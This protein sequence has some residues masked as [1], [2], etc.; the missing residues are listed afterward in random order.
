M[1]QFHL[2]VVLESLGLPVRAGLMAAAKLGVQ[3]VQ[4]DAVGDLAHDRLGATGRREFRTLLRSFNQELAAVNVPLRHGLD[5]F[6]HQ[7][8]RLDHVKQVMQLAYELG[9]KKVVVPLPRLPKAEDKPAAEPTPFLF[10][11]EPSRAEVLKESLLALGN[12]GD[13]IGVLVCLEAGLDSGAEVAAHLGG[14]E[15]G[16]LRVTFDPANF[17]VNGHDPLASLMSL[18]KL[19]A[20]VHARDARTGTAASGPKEVAVGAGE[21]EWMGLVAGLSA[22]DY[23][24]FVC[25]ERTGAE[26]EV[27][28]GVSFLRRFIPMPAG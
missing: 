1:S 10:F 28:S 9:A 22:T 24:G 15:C 13:R 16:S 7:Q 3:G 11:K 5:T 25:V 26:N 19:V 14:F 8:Q 20:H 12:H 17:L 21:V 4:A 23:R 6:A 2:G 27:A 18:S